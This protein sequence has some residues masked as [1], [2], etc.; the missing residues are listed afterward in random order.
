MKT[1]GVLGG[2]FDPVHYGHLRLALEMR[3]QLGLVRVCMIPAATPPLRD[4]PYAAP[5][6]RLRMLEA[7]IADEAALYCDDRELHRSGTS[8]TVDTLMSLRNDLADTAICLILGMDAF[9]RLEHW[10][11][12]RELFDLA[13]ICVAKR[14]G[15]SQVVEG[16]LGELVNERQTSDVGALADTAAGRICI[17]DIPA[18]DV[19]ATHIRGLVSTGRSARYLLPDAVLDII[20]RQGLYRHEQ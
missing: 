12:W 7:A 10:H 18:L 9:I 19:S 3:E 15:S 11:R 14:P 13:H 2:T 6:L 17:R 4:T 1:I 16:E 20:E 8:F 5:A